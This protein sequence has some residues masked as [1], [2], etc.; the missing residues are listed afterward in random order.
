MIVVTHEMRFAQKAA[1]RA[2]FIDGGMIVE[3]GPPI[4][5]LQNPQT[6]RL[7]R[8]LNLIFWGED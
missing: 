8:F 5:I 4:S 7:K 2:I 1:S 3:E 6:E